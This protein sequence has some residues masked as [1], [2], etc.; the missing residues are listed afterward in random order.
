[1]P[2]VSMPNPDGSRTLTAYADATRCWVSITDNATGGALGWEIPAASAQQMINGL[3]T[4]MKTVWPT[5]T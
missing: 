5:I 1:M 2:Q 3:R 4:M